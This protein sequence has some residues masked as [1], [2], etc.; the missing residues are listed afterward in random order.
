[1]LRI[2]ILFINF[3]VYPMNTFK[4]VLASFIIA[5]MSS[6]SFAVANPSYEEVQTP[7][8]LHQAALKR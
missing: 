1:L 2:N 4:K 8:S 6:T 7:R 5:A 3:E